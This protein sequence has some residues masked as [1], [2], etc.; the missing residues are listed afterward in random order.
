[1]ATHSTN[2]DYPGASHENPGIAWA[3]TSI[4]T[5]DGSKLQCALEL[6][7]EKRLIGSK[8]LDEYFPG[9]RR[10]PR[11]GEIAQNVEVLETHRDS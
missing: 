11:D 2:E 6:G 10:L 3:T 8:T 4:I 1:M 7:G 5:P 9:S